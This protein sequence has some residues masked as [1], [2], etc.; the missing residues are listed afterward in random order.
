MWSDD[1]DCHIAAE[2]TFKQQEDSVL[3]TSAQKVEK[4]L[5][6]FICKILSQ[7]ETYSGK[8]RCNLRGKKVNVKCFNSC[9]KPL[10]VKHDLVTYCWSFIPAIIFRLMSGTLI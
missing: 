5:T 6:T 7:S 3:I 8:C 9:K 10:Q 4:E 1:Y 2:Y